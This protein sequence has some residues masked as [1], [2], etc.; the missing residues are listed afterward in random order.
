MDY[1]VKSGADDARTNF[2]F[3]YPSR[4]RARVWG[5]LV[6]WNLWIT[7]ENGIFKISRAYNKVPLDVE[8]VKEDG[9]WKVARME[10]VKGEPE[11]AADA[12]IIDDAEEKQKAGKLSKEKVQLLE[13]IH[14]TDAVCEREYGSFEE[15][16]QAAQEIEFGDFNGYALR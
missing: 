8:L 1:I 9:S 4:D 2:M 7:E 13:T 6:G 15:A 12:G 14:H 11:T 10:G 3:Y 16:L 5:E